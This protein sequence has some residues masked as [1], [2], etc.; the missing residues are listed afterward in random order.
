[1]DR[2]R[3]TVRSTIATNER[4]R[5]RASTVLRLNRA[6]NYLTILQFT[7]YLY[8]SPLLEAMA[9]MM[10]RTSAA[11]PISGSRIPPMTTR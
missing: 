4:P 11:M 7:G 1:M 8:C 6:A 3:F 2:T 10:Q 5:A 9:A